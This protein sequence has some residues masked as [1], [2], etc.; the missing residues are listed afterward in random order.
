VS[1]L[2]RWLAP[3]AEDLWRHSAANRATSATP[4]PNAGSAKPS[5]VATG[6]L[7]P[8]NSL[9]PGAV[10]CGVAIGSSPPA[11]LRPAENRPAAAELAEVAPLADRRTQ[12]RSCGSLALAEWHQGIVQLQTMPAQA[13]V[14]PGRWQQL[15]QDA[16]RFCDEWGAKASA[17]GW[18]TL[19]A[20]G[21]HKLKPYARLDSAGLVW[22]LGRCAV[23]ALGPD[24]ATLQFPSGSRQIYRCR[25]NAQLDAQRVPAWELAQ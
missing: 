17:L 21:A 19:D 23:L 12:H 18:S 6:L 2:D 5:R 7:L 8:A 14:P 15:K 25:R 20:F 13:D 22:F 1:R 16:L 11:I 4:S 10:A 3:A 24:A 9:R